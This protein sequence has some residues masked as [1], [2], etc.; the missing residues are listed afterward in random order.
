MDISA[1]K[2][3]S[4]SRLAILI[5]SIFVLQVITPTTDRVA[6]SASRSFALVNIEKNYSPWTE[7][8]LAA[9]SIEDSVEHFVEKAVSSKHFN[10]KSSPRKFKIVKVISK[11]K[12]SI[13][14]WPVSN[15]V[16]SGYGMRRHPITKRRSFKT[17]LEVIKLKQKNLIKSLTYWKKNRKNMVLM[18]LKL[19][20]DIIKQLKKSKLKTILFKSSKRKTKNFKPNLN[21]NRTCMKL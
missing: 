8:K 5:L 18:L 2:L 1:F 15:K 14:S 21:I 7:I 13:L 4:S 3:N 9:N 10:F 20:L 16:T 17:K 6:F 12:S 19:M 11:R